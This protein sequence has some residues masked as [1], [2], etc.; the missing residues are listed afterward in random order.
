VTE[1]SREALKVTVALEAIAVSREAK[2]ITDI[3]Y[4]LHVKKSAIFAT[5]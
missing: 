4:Y 5:S 1:V 2:T 3:S